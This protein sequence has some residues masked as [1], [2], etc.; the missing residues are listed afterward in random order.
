MPSRLDVAILIRALIIGCLLLTSNM[1]GTANDV[2]KRGEISAGE[3]QEPISLTRHQFVLLEPRAESGDAHAQCLL[4]I[5]YHHALFVRKDDAE[6]AIW[7]S[8]AAEA[9]LALAQAQLGYLYESGSGVPRNEAEAVKWYRRSAEQGL[10]KAENN[11]GHTSSRVQHPLRRLSRFF[12]HWLLSRPMFDGC[13][14][15]W[16]R[17]GNR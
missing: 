11:L 2:A 16:T 17:G 10:P 15:H 3:C 4:G 14:F 5:A 6:A 13:A 8:K 9:G 12:R 7:L 1:H